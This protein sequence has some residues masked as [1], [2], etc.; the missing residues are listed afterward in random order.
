[1]FAGTG[2]RERER[3]REREI[4]GRGEGRG[5]WLPAD[6]ASS[7]GWALQPSRTLWRSLS[8][9]FIAVPRNAIPCIVISHR[10][11]PWHGPGVALG[12]RSASSLCHPF[13]TRNLFPYFREMST[14]LGKFGNVVC[15]W[16]PLIQQRRRWHQWQ[17]NALIAPI[18]IILYTTEEDKKEEGEEREETARKQFQEEEECPLWHNQFKDR[19]Q[20]IGELQ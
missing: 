16:L 8:T 6:K 1:M 11:T 10:Q 15:R 14:L 19:S 13:A 4:E 9:A 7:A 17:I 18:V 5:F 2:E 20:E 12:R 3:E